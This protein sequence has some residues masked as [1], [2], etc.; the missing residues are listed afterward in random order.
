MAIVQ[1]KKLSV[2]VHNNERER[3][4]LAFQKAGFVH[5]DSFGEDEIIPG[6]GVCE[7]DMSSE[8]LDLYID[9]L[10]DAFEFLDEISPPQKKALIQSL[11]EVP[12]VL[13]LYKIREAYEVYDLQKVLTDIKSMEEGFR[14]SENKLK[15][16]VKERDE[17][18]LW[19]D[20]GLDLDIL[21]GRRPLLGGIAGAVPAEKGKDFESWLKQV[22]PNVE[23]FL[24]FQTDKEW[25][26]FVLYLKSEEKL[27][28]DKLREYGFLEVGISS[29]SGTIEEALKEI[30]EEIKEAKKEVEAIR[31]DILR[32]KN[33]EMEELKMCYDFLLIQK[34]GKET[35][36]KGC[37]TETV[38]IFKGWI[39]ANKEKA[40]KKIIAAFESVD[41]KVE[42]PS[43]SD[44][45]PIELKENPISWPFEVLTRMYG[46]PQYGKTV[47]PTPHFSLFYFLFFGFCL[48][49]FVY[50]FLMLLIFGYLAFLSREKKEVARFM[51]FLA[52]N[53]FSTMIFGAIFG[54]Y[55]GDFFTVYVKLPFLLN[56]IK[57]IA[58]FDPLKNP[59]IIL[60]YA[61]LLG[62]IQIIYGLAIKMFQGFKEGFIESFFETFPWIVFL[63]GAFG[64]LVLAGI[65]SLTPG[66][67]LVGKG[68]ADFLFYCI[69]VGTGLIV[70][71][72]IRKGKNI[73]TGFFGGLYSL[74]GSSSFLGDLLS[75]ARLLALGIST[76]VIAMVFNYIAFMLIYSF[77][78]SWNILGIMVYSIKALIGVCILIGAHLFNLVMSAFGAFIHS[79]RLQF[80]EFFSKFYS[81]GGKAYEPL[82]EEGFYYRIKEETGG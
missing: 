21:N 6:F 3:L 13:P 42:N 24:S 55:L 25:Y 69:L 15:S 28:K 58:L 22:S 1:M 61:L 82:K 72:G 43:G 14:S 78:Q 62:A 76:G 75:Y 52:V 38:S 57:K 54:S 10:K 65:P 81:S 17:L 20:S 36:K 39:P 18:S 71:N 35:Q 9:D 27:I 29:R 45:V 56:I 19:K 74:Y 77:P 30:D 32:I 8:E 70:L 63:T 53:G 51:V 4:F 33:E 5:I 26:Y 46:L 16:L 80:V 34:K 12:P 60:Y 79:A 23:Q 37:E 41:Y 40:F 64:L 50:G 7:I 2:I 73:I 59:M 49:D 44:I 66:L 68:I 11:R 31:K 67:P 48:S 47:D